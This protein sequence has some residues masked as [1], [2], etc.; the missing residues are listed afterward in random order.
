MGPGETADFE[1]TPPAPGTWRIDVSTVDGGWRIAVPLV[2]KAKPK[3]GAK[4]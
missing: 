1:F 4:R 2:V 3:V